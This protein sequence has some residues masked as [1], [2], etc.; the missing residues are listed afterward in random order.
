MS[1]AGQL[2]ELHVLTVGE[3]E[4]RGAEEIVRVCGLKVGLLSAIITLS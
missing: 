2:L 1:L 3:L 4:R